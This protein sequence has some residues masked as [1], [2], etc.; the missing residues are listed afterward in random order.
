[1]QLPLLKDVLSAMNIKILEQE[2]YEADDIIGTIA[3]EAEA[4]GMEAIVITGDKDELQLATDNTKI[5][6]TRRGV[7]EFEVFDRKAFIDKYGFEPGLFVDF[8]GMMGDQSDNIPGIPGVGEK[9][10]LKFMREYGN[11]ENFLEHRDELKGKMKE[12]VCG[13]VET[14]ILSKRLATIDTHVPMTVDFEEY[15]LLPK[16]GRAS[17]RERV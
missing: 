4:K 5:I 11:L 12:K 8:K 1:M 7:S 14:A 3:R 10:A 6:I 9:T 17:C 15:K 2:G 13:N 16:I